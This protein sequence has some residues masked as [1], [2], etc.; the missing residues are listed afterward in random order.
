MLGLASLIGASFSTS[1][2]QA[3]T[4]AWPLRSVAV[5]PAGKVIILMDYYKLII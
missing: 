3:K 2:S 1:S 5:L 4:T